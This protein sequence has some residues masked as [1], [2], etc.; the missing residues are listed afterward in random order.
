MQQ[1]MLNKYAVNKITDT[2][3]SL[4]TIFTLWTG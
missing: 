2:S 3:R 1:H 4:A